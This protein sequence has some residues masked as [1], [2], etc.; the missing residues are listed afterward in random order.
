MVYKLNIFIVPDNTDITKIKE[1]GE[2]FK[3]S[4]LEGAK[5]PSN[6]KDVSNNNT[7]KKKKDPTEIKEPIAL[8]L[9][10]TEK[11]KA[12][13]FL[14]NPKWQAKIKQKFFDDP[15]P[16]SHFRKIIFSFTKN[17][18]KN[19]EDKTLPPEYK[20]KEMTELF[21]F[22][23]QCEK[24]PFKLFD[25][26]KKQLFEEIQKRIKTIFKKG[27]KINKKLIWDT[28][29]PVV[30]CDYVWQ[31]QKP[32]KNKDKTKTCTK[33]QHNNYEW[34]ICNDADPN[35]KARK[36][37]TK[38]E[39][40]LEIQK[41][42]KDEIDVVGTAKVIETGSSYFD[43]LAKVDED[44]KKINVLYHDELL[45]DPP[46][47]NK[48][49]KYRQNIVKEILK[50]IE[51]QNDKNQEILKLSGEL[52]IAKDAKTY[53]DNFKKQMKATPLK[54]SFGYLYLHTLSCYDKEFQKNYRTYAERKRLADE[55]IKEIEEK[56]SSDSFAMQ[57]Q[58]RKDVELQIVLKGSVK[59]AEKRLQR[60]VHF[61]ICN[62]DVIR[63]T[64]ILLEKITQ[65]S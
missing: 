56:F 34:Q 53:F 14:K 24:K 46:K 61:R 57:M 49:E 20:S 40:I 41:K 45:K 47:E 13:K 25:S 19:K 63:N 6:N 3:P 55:K 43:E 2:L 58:R 22:I 31:L 16:H 5:D 37:K 1:K 15:D 11:M 59:K 33:Y 18:K 38:W 17:K 30:V 26:Q 35:E 60:Q 65:I 62:I 54:Q 39:K 36:S 4:M 21:Q 8:N 23:A 29:K 42:Y 64:T 44:I 32:Q 9:T 10:Y 28:K 50:N 7:P 27:T 48:R 52:K 51:F 12:I